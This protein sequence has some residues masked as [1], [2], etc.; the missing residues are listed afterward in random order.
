MQISA[1]HFQEEEIPFAG[2][3]RESFMEEA[4]SDLGHSVYMESFDHLSVGGGI[5]VEV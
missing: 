4:A 1:V 3:I 2:E 5:S